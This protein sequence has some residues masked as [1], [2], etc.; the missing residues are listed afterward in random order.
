M[1]PK[2]IGFILLFLGC[3]LAGQEY[4]D[5][6]VADKVMVQ[7]TNLGGPASRMISV[8][9]PGGF[10]YAFNAVNCA[11]RFVWFGGFL[12]FSGEANGR[13]G[14][15]GKVLGIKRTLG[16]EAVPFRVENPDSLPVSLVFG[17]YRRDSDTGDPTFLIEVDGVSVEQRLLSNDPDVV[18]IELM[19]PK[20]TQVMMYY[21][22]DSSVHSDVELSEGLRWG[23]PSVIEIPV[24]TSRATLTIALK[25]TDKTFTRKEPNLS[26]EQVFKN[27]CNACHSTDGTKLIGPSF[28]GLWGRTQT[29]TREGKTETIIV[30]EHYLH[31]SIMEPQAAV[32]TGFELVP[33]ADFSSVLTEVQLERLVGYLRTLE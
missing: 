14:K 32:V 9:H 13:G 16:I 10:N 20:P 23:A 24:K 15:G 25:P 31:E 11:P 27:F 29:V 2:T 17:G 33:M 26:G 12:D 18:K 7:R 22:L 4:R 21:R 3:S 6:Y 8:G 5:I 30:D 28:D 1:K 19:F